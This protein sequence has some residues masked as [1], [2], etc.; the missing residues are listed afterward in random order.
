MTPNESD[1]RMIEYLLGELPR[2]Q[3]LLLEERY[4]HDGEYFESLQALEHEL[5][6]DFVNDEMAPDLRE[7]FERRYRSSR[8]LAEKIAFVEAIRSEA[9]KLREGR[10]RGL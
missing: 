2:D 10:Q 8:D 4:F 5:I 7:R 6:R 9:G 3:A 1:Q